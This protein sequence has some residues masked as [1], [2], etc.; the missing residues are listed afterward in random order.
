MKIELKQDEINEIIGKINNQIEIFRYAHHK[1]PTFI[2]ISRDLE[3]V[4]RTQFR[5]LS[6]YEAVRLN[7]EYLEINRLFGICCFVSPVL[8]GL[9]FEIR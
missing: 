4:L 7:N 6:Q 3:M 5:L 2:I 9:D 8:S 1:R